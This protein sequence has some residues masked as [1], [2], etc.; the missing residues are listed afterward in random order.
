MTKS[1]LIVD[2]EEADRYLLKRQIR[3][4]QPDL[5]I[6][7]QANGREAIDFLTAFDEG[8]AQYSDGFPPGLI[9]LDIN[10]PL[11]NGW[12]FLDEL[13]VLRKSADLESC[14]IMMFSSSD[15]DDDRSRI[16]DY[17]FATDYLVKGNVPPDQMASILTEHCRP[18]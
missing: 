10:M 5:Q 14:V 6:H 17:D 13:S 2:D 18:G 16:T 3:S 9:F 1:V 12:E 11:M 4:S 15:S 7:E 8:V